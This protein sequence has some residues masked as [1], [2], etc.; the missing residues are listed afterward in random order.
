MRRA[1]ELS[2]RTILNRAN[3]TTLAILVLAPFPKDYDSALGILLLLGPR[4]GCVL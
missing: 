1:G 4:G 2:Y 3:Q